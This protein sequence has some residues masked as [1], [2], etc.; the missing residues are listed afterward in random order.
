MSD[1]PYPGAL[2]F[3]DSGLSKGKTGTALAFNGV[4]PLGFRF[5]LVDVHG[6]RTR[7]IKEV[8]LKPSQDKSEDKKEVGP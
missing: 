5:W 4:S 7:S 3:I 6:H 2:V 1:F 8:W